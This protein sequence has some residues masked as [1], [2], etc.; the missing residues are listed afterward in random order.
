MSEETKASAAYSVRHRKR[1]T[2]YKV[3]GSAVLQVADGRVLKDGEPLVVYIGPSGMYVRAK[4][5]FDDG[6]FE[7]LS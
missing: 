7:V 3:L 6:R 2:G 5:E 4:D 1:G